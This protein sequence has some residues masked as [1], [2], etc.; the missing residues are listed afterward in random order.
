M[1]MNDEIQIAAPREK[2]FEKL[3]DAGVLKAC[4]PGCETLEKVSE[5]EMKAT[6]M[7]KVGP[8]RSRFNG[9]V[10]LSDV[11]PPESYTIS[12][13][14]RGGAA[15]FAK[16]AA[17]V[18]LVESGEGTLLRYDVKA[19][20]GGKL[21]QLG[22]RLIDATARSY[23]KDFFNAFKSEVEGAGGPAAGEPEAEGLEDEL[24]MD[25]VPVQAGGVDMRLW[26]MLAAAV[27]VV[28]MLVAIN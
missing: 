15:G 25:A 11:N 21:A 26:L 6:V 17:N 5:S 23:A 24:P 2:V 16:G 28:V 13:E 22:S 27:A 3:N 14:G 8:V 9:T 18:H 7:A 19:D 4:I 10:R 20:V 1:Q 12:G